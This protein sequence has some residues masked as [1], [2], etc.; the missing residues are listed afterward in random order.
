MTAQGTS[1][2]DLESN[3]PVMGVGG[4]QDLVQSILKDLNMGNSGNSGGGNVNMMPPPAGYMK[5]TSSGVINSPNPNDQ[6]FPMATDPMIGN[7]PGKSPAHMIGK[8]F[9]TEADF[10]V[11]LNQKQGG[12]AGSAVNQQ[13]GP[14]GAYMPSPH[15]IVQAPPPQNSTLYSSLP[16]LSA[17]GLIDQ[18]KQPFLVALIIF[19]ISLPALNVLIATYAPSLLRSGGDLTTSGLVV[20]ALIGGGLYWILQNVIVPL[21]Q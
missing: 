7:Q 2:S 1:L 3:T 8:S 11:L 13:F 10:S 18:L 16:T 20:R 4:D 15:Y 14:G 17:T 19:I 21:C 12:M 9:P 6:V 5:G